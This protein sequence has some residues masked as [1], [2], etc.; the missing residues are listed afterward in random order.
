MLN[1][2]NEYTEQVKI[3]LVNPSHPGNIGAVA[4]AIKNMGFR[5]LYL[6]SPQRF[7]SPEA[8]ARASG[9]EDILDSAVV[10]ET[11]EQALEDCTLVLGLSS[12]VREI[13]W[14]TLDARDAAR[15][16]AQEL[17]KMDKKIDRTEEMTET[18]KKV[19][20]ESIVS[21]KSSIALVFGQEQCGL[22]NEEL[23]RCHYQVMINAN[24]EYASLNLAQAVQILTYECRMAIFENNKAIGKAFSAEDKADT[25]KTDENNDEDKN[26]EIA[27]AAEM[28]QYYNTLEQMLVD[29]EFLDPKVPRHLML[30]L[31][32][33]YA[34][35]RPD[36]T[37]LNI[38]HGMCRAMKKTAHQKTATQEILDPKKC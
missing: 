21:G 33:L 25:D 4:R 18:L 22:L 23:M 12:R 17:I 28:E 29:I 36:K 24:P 9:A 30:R 3:V 1:L 20:F 10:T 16:V 37:E 2:Y 8:N 34:K 14:P 15:L 5:A 13:P 19:P 26:S 11:L 6:V 7:P 31:R 32:R 35:A 38:L 27:T